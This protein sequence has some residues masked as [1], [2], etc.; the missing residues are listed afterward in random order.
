LL[1]YPH[2]Q[3]LKSFFFEGPLGDIS[4]VYRDTMTLVSTQTN[5][6]SDN[7]STCRSRPSS[8]IK[9]CDPT[10]TIINSGTPKVTQQI[11]GYRGHIPLNIRNNI[12]MAHSYGEHP[13]PV[14]NDLLLTTKLSVLGYTGR[15]N[16]IY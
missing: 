4:T 7:S 6:V 16:K 8:P 5:I 2:I 1:L 13:H 14:Q 10:S 9:R 12:K 11:P 15:L 3:L